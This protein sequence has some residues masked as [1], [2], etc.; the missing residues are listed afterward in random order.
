MK[1]VPL[2]ERAIRKAQQEFRH[3]WPAFNRWWVDKRAELG[4]TDLSGDMPLEP[5]EAA[6]EAYLRASK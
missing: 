4:L 6:V 5:F 3:H 1:H 2:N